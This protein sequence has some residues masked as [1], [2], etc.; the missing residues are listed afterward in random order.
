MADSIT[1]PA[2]VKVG[3]KGPGAD[4]QDYVAELITLAERKLASRLG[5]LA[6]WVG[7]DDRR[8]QAV[9][10]VVSEMVKR[11]LRSGGSEMKAES[12]GEYSYEVDPRVSSGSLWVTDENW[13][14][15]MGPDPDPGVGTIRL[16][17]PEY[18][19]PV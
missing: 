7:T 13:E 15:L 14:T 5:E 12:D 11:V 1:L 3:Y 2:D 10:D 8:R 9:K 19:W 4:D 18:R 16:K 6:T 17:I